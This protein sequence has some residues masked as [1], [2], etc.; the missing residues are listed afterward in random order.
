M[1]LPNSTNVSMV[2]GSASAP[3]AIHTNAVDLS[4]GLLCKAWLK[5][6]SDEVKAEVEPGGMAEQQVHKGYGGH[7]LSSNDGRYPLSPGLLK[8]VRNFHRLDINVPGQYRTDYGVRPI[9]S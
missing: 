8:F 4:K 9:Y 1:M 5:K 7:N 2:L 6:R 3:N